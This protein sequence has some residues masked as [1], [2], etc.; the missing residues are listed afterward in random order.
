MLAAEN[1]ASEK[2]F[3]EL[4]EHLNYLNDVY[5]LAFA[6]RMRLDGRKI[7]DIPDVMRAQFMILMRLTDF[8][9]CIQLLCVKGYPEQAG[10]LAAS[11]F[12]LGHTAAFFEHSA[13]KAA[14]WLNSRSIKEHMPRAVLGVTWKYVVQQNLE[15]LGDGTGAVDEY[16][17]YSQL[18]WMKHSLPKMQDMRVQS[19][20]VSLI[21][22]PYT[23][24]RS[25][26][27]VWFSMEHAGRLTEMVVHIL[28]MKFGDLEL[29][30]ALNAVT[31]ARESLRLKAI[32][33]FGDVNPLLEGDLR[34]G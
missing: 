3:P 13:A 12:E 10:T 2:I 32:D 17:V 18:C 1:E 23:D 9:R 31:Q 33:R 19:D 28:A 24:E 21:F 11:V 34:G 22:G 8:L 4:H 30:K 29:S 26:S 25:I 6:V 20:G 7:S 27:H 15:R 14:A 16:Q 5:N